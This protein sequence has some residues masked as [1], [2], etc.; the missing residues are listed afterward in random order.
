MRSYRAM[1]TVLLL[2][3]LG[4][5]SQETLAPLA[6]VSNGVAISRAELP[7]LPPSVVDAPISYALAPALDGLE[8]A[9]PRTFGDINKRI[10]I[11]SNTRQ[12]IAFAASRTPFDVDFDGKQLTISTVVSYMGKGWYNPMIGPTIGASCGTDDVQPRLNVVINTRVDIEKNWNL[13]TRTTLKSIQPATDSTRDQCRVTAFNIDVTDKVVSSISPFLSGRLPDV[14]QKIA[15]FDVRSRVDK[16]YNL[17]NKSIRVHDSLWLVLAPK[18]VR[19]GAL[20]LTDSALVANVRLYAQPFMV[21]GPKPPQD[22]T[23]LPAFTRAD[24][25]VGDSAHLR[26]EGLL[27]YEDA[28]STLNAALRGRTFRRFNQSVKIDSARFYA[29]GDGRVVLGLKLKGS[30]VGDAYLV[31]TPVLD[32]VT[33]M[34]TVPDLDFDVAT[35][36]DLVRGLAWL[37]KGDLVAELRKRARLPLEPLLDDTRQKVEGALNRRLTEGVML[38][39]TIT[40]GRLIDVAAT[41]RWLVVRAE[42]TGTLA[43]NIDRAI[44]VKGRKSD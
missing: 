44:P 24:A 42:A 17:L 35:A 34:L 11:P 13:K 3:A 23:R 5:C 12:Q 1:S 41:L 14:D 33:R 32:T 2:F 38:A 43:L 8:R 16:W 27:S 22:Y 6:P 19:M 37:K 28:S 21:S 10:T 25:A 20:A 9:V 18:D 15:R 39:G 31:G 40:T 36:D 4:A 29:L 30:I 26:L 7:P